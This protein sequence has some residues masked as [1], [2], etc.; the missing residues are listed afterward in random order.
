M[1]CRWCR[2]P[3]VASASTW[4]GPRAR[5]LCR[6]CSETFAGHR[7]HLAEPARERLAEI[8]GTLLSRLLSVF[9]PETRAMRRLV[10]EADAFERRQR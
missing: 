9:D 6:R 2:Q 3:A 1:T 4:S 10:A 5:G 8:D 7:A